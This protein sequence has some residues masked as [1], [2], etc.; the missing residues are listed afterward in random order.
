MPELSRFYGI[1]IKMF[2]RQREHAPPHFHVVY[3]NSVGIVNLETLEMEEGDLPPRALSMVREWAELHRT[4][5]LEVWNTQ[6][7]RKIEP[8]A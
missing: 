7:F 1:A 5:L 6:N 3:G 4:E 8:L 2:F